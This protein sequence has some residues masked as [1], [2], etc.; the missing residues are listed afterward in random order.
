MRYEQEVHKYHENTIATGSE[1][2]H[3]RYL[4]K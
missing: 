2:V 1:N 3:P 4:G